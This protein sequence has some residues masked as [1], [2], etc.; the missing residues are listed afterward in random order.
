M[1]RPIFQNAIP[2]I[3]S[4]VGIFYVADDIYVI[5]KHAEMLAD[6]GD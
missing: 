5:R 6:A 1:K 2:T 4:A 3:L